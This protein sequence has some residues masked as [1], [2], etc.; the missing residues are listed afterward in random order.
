MSTG[1]PALKPIAPDQQT[2]EAERQV[3]LAVAHD[4]GRLPNSNCVQDLLLLIAG[5]VRLHRLY[6]E[7]SFIGPDSAQTKAF[8]KVAHMFERGR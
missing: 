3:R 1:A 2:A 7:D 6:A 4:I 5:A 8:L